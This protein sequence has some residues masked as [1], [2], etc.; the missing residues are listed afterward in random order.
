ME[1]PM[2]ETKTIQCPHCSKP[3]EFDPVLTD[4]QTSKRLASQRDAARN[5]V[6]RLELVLV[7]RA[8]TVSNL[9]SRLDEQRMD[10]ERLAAN[11][12]TYRQRVDA[13]QKALDKMTKR[14]SLMQR[15]FAVF[16]GK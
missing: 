14:P 12:E 7:D 1:V 2:A 3:V 13:L 9:E 6:Q 8:R 11:V 5:E 4:S 16:G 10:N 15:T